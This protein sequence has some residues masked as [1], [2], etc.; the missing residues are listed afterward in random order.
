MAQNNIQPPRYSRNM[1]SNYGI[2]DTMML[3]Y[4]MNHMDNPAYAMLF[5]A[6]RH[7]PGMMLFMSAMHKDGDKERIRQLET[8]IAKM[9]HNGVAGQ[10]G[11]V[12]KQMGDLVLS[13]E[14]VQ[15]MNSNEVKQYKPKIIFGTASDS[16]LFYQF[17]QFFQRASN[18]KIAV[19]LA[20]TKGSMH[21]LELLEKGKID[22]C[23]VSQNTLLEYGIKHPDNKLTATMG[24]MF[25]EYAHLIGNQN[26]GLISI[27]DLNPKKYMVSYGKDSSMLTLMQDLSHEHHDY[28]AFLPSS[29]KGGGGRYLNEGPSSSL[30]S[31]L[32]KKNVV[33]LFFVGLNSKLLK[34]ANKHDDELRLLHVEG[35]KRIKGIKDQF[36]N[37]VY[38]TAKIPWT[39]Y[40]SGLHPGF[41]V[42]GSVNTIKTDAIL[43]LSNKW[44]KKYGQSGMDVFNGTVRI[45]KSQ[46]KKVIED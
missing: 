5:Y 4:A 14:A 26:A 21:N 13:Q 15:A 34:Q 6:N 38:E 46:I 17:G 24:T 22:A 45:A 40:A 27:K 32:N 35:F 42:P 3:C 12:P 7:N 37:Q 9:E 20:K 28:A 31:V 19:R 30:S 41:L 23:L 29:I 1:S 43:V 18:G 2:Y 36:G 11:Y 33:M 10:P 25:E 16:G 39:T 44:G 8:R